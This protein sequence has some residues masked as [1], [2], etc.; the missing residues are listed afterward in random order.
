MPAAVVFGGAYG[1]MKKP[2]AFALKKSITNSV[3]N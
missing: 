2:V 3:Y 1:K